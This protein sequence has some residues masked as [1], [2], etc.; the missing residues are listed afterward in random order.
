MGGC[1]AQLDGVSARL[2]GRVRASGG[3]GIDTPGGGGG[4]RLCGA[5]GVGIGCGGG[6][7]GDGWVGARDGSGGSTR[8]PAT[9]A[10]RLAAGFLAM[11]RAKDV[12]QA[13]QH[14][15]QH[16]KVIN[17]DKSKICTDW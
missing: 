1:G 15:P 2:G 5:V 7:S 13:P 4:A 9:A 17:G 12:E 3:N 14:G 6:V 10:A 11:P 16:N 8:E